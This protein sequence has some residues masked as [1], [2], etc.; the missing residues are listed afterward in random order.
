MARYPDRVADEFAVYLRSYASVYRSAQRTGEFWRR[1]AG[2][3]RTG[4]P[5]ETRL[6]PVP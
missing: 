4:G 3:V 1:R 6:A 5:R 2:S